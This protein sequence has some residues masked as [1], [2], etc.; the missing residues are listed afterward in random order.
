MGDEASDLF[1]NI[2]NFLDEALNIL[3]DL[4]IKKIEATNAMYKE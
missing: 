3:E 1:D 2:S 4:K